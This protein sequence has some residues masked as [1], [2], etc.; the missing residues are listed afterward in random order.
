MESTVWKN[1][2]QGF[3]DQHPLVDRELC[4][5]RSGPMSEGLIARTALEYHICFYYPNFGIGR[6]VSE[7]RDRATLP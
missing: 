7:I 5:L 6:I 1:E 3:R 2:G 4:A